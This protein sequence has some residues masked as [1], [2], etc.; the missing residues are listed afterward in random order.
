VTGIIEAES[1]LLA[2]MS[3]TA[4]VAYTYTK[5][6]EYEES[7][8]ETDAEGNR[9]T[10]T[11]KGTEQLEAKDQRIRFYVRDSTG[12]VQVD[13]T[14]ADI[15]LQETDQRYDD[16]DEPTRSGRRTLGFRETERALPIGTQVYILGCAVDMFGEPT[17]ARHPGDSKARF[18]ISWRSEQELAERASSASSSMR[19]AAMVFGVLGVV[20]LVASLIV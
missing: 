10:E 9:S 7:V 1:P 6:R 3:N 16:R 20:L 19:N 8:V 15:D 5:V 12:R 18:L 14:E 11:R 13:P 17:V 4:C 2:P